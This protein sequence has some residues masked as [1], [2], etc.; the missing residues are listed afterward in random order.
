MENYRKRFIR[1]YRVKK[2]ASEPDAVIKR[3]TSRLA[4]HRFPTHVLKCGA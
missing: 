3:A 1:D 2:T 4:R